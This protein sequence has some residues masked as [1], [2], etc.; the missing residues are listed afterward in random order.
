MHNMG[1]RGG[2]REWPQIQALQ[3]MLMANDNVLP[4]NNLLSLATLLREALYIEQDLARR[5]SQHPDDVSLLKQH[6]EYR[7]LVRHLN[8]ELESALATYVARI[9]AAGPDGCTPMG[10]ARRSAAASRPK[11]RRIPAP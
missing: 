6:R 3:L 8:G 7:Q 2:S 9:K 11:G 1:T 5:L 10:P 4:G